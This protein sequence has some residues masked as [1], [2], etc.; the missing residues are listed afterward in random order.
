M[1]P[2]ELDHPAITPIKKA[3]HSCPGSGRLLSMVL[4][5]LWH[6]VTAQKLNSLP[7]PNTLSSPHRKWYGISS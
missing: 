2:H 1:K 6:P 5:A 7:M 3:S 4:L